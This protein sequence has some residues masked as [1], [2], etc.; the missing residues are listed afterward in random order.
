MLMSATAMERYTHFI[1]TYSDI[2]QK[3][4]QKMITFYLGISPVALSSIRK[5]LSTHL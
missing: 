5:A 1:E 4:P 3:G 2:T